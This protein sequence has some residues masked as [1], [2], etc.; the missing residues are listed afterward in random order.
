[1]RCSTIEKLLPLYVEGDIRE[2][3]A[4]KVQ[5]HLSSCDV[6]RHVAEE[7]RASQNLVHAYD[8]PEFDEEF[9]EQLRA[10]VL[11]GINSV[12]PARPSFFEALRPLFI[13]RRAV[14]T[15][16]LLFLFIFGAFYGLLYRRLSNSSSYMAAIEKGLG[17]INPGEF[18]PSPGNRNAAAPT[19]A[20]I[21]GNP[22]PLSFN[23]RS[24][25][26]QKIKPGALDNAQREESTSGNNDAATAATA[27]ARTNNSGATDTASTQ[28]V[29][30][31]EIQTSDPNIRIIWLARK[32]SE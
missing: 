23:P 24:G 32:P 14:A 4:S 1:M 22:R 19:G 5:A 11:T 6:C 31:M 9:Y 18:A 25:S 29:A 20:I 16:C 8:A 17:E 26:R 3:E 12:Q 2:G 27:Q 13:K 7:F 28:A 10:T 21:E 30:R 15:A